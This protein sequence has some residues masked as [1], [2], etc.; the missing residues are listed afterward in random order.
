MRQYYDV[1]SPD[2]FSISMDKTWDSK[3]KAKDALLQFVYKYK[4]QGY[5]SK[6]DRTK[7]PFSEI[8]DQCKIIKL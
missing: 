5:Y 4:K 3:M 1:L 6:S 8:Y 2:G 7:I